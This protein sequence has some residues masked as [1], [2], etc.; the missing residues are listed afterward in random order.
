[1][2]VYPVSGSVIHFVFRPKNVQSPEAG[3]ARLGADT[4]AEDRHPM[5]KK[6]RRPR[7]LHVSVCRSA[8]GF[9]CSQAPGSHTELPR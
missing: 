4:T 7:R 5:Q 6:R 2:F 9:D 3:F 8:A 1:M